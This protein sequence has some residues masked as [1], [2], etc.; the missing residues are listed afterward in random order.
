ME[1]L[2]D[3][4]VEIESVKKTQTEIK[5]GIK[6]LEYQTKKTLGKFHQQ[7]KDKEEKSQVLK[8]WR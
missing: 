7:L 3:M 2:Q 6:S 1:A 4:K 5:L 8:K